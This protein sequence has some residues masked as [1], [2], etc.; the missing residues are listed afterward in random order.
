VVLTNDYGVE[1]LLFHKYISP[2]TGPYNYIYQVENYFL[3]KISPHSGTYKYSR[4]VTLIFLAIYH[5]TVGHT[6]TYVIDNSVSHKYI[7]TQGWFLKIHHHTVAQINTYEA[8]G[9]FPLHDP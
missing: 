8:L 5:R 3:R 4:S 1:N 7:A 9:S 6:N 2:Y